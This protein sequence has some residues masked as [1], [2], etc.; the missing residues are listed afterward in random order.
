MRDPRCAMRLARPDWRGYAV[1][2]GDAAVIGGQSGFAEELRVTL[3]EVY[4]AS[5]GVEHP[6]WDDYDR[7]MIEQERVAV[8]PRPSLTCAQNLS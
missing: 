2:D 4:R 1:L 7:A 8:L 5:A 6:D 3:R